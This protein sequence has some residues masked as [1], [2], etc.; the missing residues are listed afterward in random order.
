MSKVA[1]ISISNVSFTDR[2]VQDGFIE[3]FA[4]TFARMGNEVRCYV[5]VPYLEEDAEKDIKKFKPDV[6]ISFNNVFMRE[7]LFKAVSCPVC[8][9]GY[10]SASFWENLD[11]VRKNYDR[12]YFIHHGEDTY[13][14]SHKLL[15][16]APEYHHF[17]FGYA[18]DLRKK[19]IPQNI[20]I[21]FIGGLGNWNR[22]LPNYFMRMYYERRDFSLNDVKNKVI[23]DMEAL[24]KNHLKIIKKIPNNWE[25]LGL[26]DYRQATILN[27]TA[28]KR[29][30]VLRNVADLGLKVFSYPQ[31]IDVIGWDLN[32]AKAFDFTPSVS[33][34]DSEYN[35]NRS[36]ISLNLPHAH[37]QVGF[38]CR[39][40]AIMASNACLL[41]DYRRDLGLL[42][43]PYFKNF[44]MFTS[45]AEAREISQKLLKETNYRKDIVAASQ[46]MV[47]ENCRFE[48]KI[49]GLSEMLNI[50][51]DLE[52]KSRGSVYKHFEE[53]RK[54]LNNAEVQE[55]DKYQDKSSKKKGSKLNLKKR[56]KLFVNLLL[57]ALWQIPILDLGVRKKNREH[58]LN[59]IHKYWR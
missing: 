15:P 56:F 17:I 34:E 22:S 58:I 57:L 42:M 19:N 50:P 43:K 13:S 36:K 1:I 41:S 39:V 9:F 35:F 33:L 38:S 44:P 11:L 46:Q 40:C 53:Y 52:D 5:I 48:K 26:L 2:I 23:K 59:K 20:N 8:I 21:S 55:G 28:L 25:N 51:F 3:G 54:K 31:F 7:R 14:Q 49:Q 27:L 30:D 18:S 24:G 4:N 32:L 45:S 47:D 37:A 12:Y 29:F 16:D 6:I 10:D